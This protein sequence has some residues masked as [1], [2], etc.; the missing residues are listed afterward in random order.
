MHL[1]NA[2]ASSAPHLLSGPGGGNDLENPEWFIVPLF[3]S[4]GKPRLKT[5]IASCRILPHEPGP[6]CTGG[7][8]LWSMGLKNTVL[9]FIKCKDE[10]KRQ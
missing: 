1:K 6:Y 4:E 9:L 10:L 2:T 8:E 5:E 3:V 7:K